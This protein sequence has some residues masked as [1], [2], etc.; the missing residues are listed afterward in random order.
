MELEE[1]AGMASEVDFVEL[2]AALAAKQLQTA[3][4]R[5][6]AAELATTQ[7]RKQKQTHRKTETC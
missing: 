1:A 6:Q 5:R 2:E 3:T 7:A 4:L